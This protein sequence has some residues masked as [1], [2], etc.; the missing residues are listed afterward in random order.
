MGSEVE[1]GHLEIWKIVSIFLG[2]KCQPQRI[3]HQHLELSTA[4]LKL[5]RYIFSHIY[6]RRYEARSAQECSPSDSAALTSALWKI[7]SRNRS[8][9]WWISLRISFLL[10]RWM[11]TP[12]RGENET[13]NSS[14]SLQRFW[15]RKIS[16]KS[17]R[18]D[19]RLIFREQNM[20][21]LDEYWWDGFDD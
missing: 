21:C 10:K 2:L 3:D 20:R 14:P 1:L 18:C 19:D 4:L 5:Y 15:R 6:Y 16:W 12:K 13:V 9:L 11:M 17:L 8:L 7:F